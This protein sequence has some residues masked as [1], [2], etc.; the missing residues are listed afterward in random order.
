MEVLSRIG[1]APEDYLQTLVP[2]IPITIQT[3][4]LILLSPDNSCGSYPQVRGLRLQLRLPIRLK[5]IMLKK[6]YQIAS[7]MGLSLFGLL[8]D[9]SH[10]RQEDSRHGLCSRNTAPVGTKFQI[11]NVCLSQFDRAFVYLNYFL[12]V[13]RP[14]WRH[15]DYFSDKLLS[16]ELQNIMLACL[17][18]SGR[19]Y[20]VVRLYSLAMV[21]R[22]N[23]C[24]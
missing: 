21:C 17:F 1:N 23:N 12:I 2:M 10:L 3:L 7:Q 20:A 18:N 4:S 11:R 15:A 8:Q 5:L 19:E 22:K 14:W 9:I 13:H 24:I 16:G 6:P